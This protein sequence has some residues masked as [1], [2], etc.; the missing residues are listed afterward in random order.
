VK[1][2]C[3]AA[4]IAV[5]MPLT[6]QAQDT[7]A[8]GAFITD[9]AAKNNFNGSV[10]IERN[11]K[12]IYTKSFGQADFAFAIPNTPDT[13]Y[14]I[15]SITKLFTS[16]LI[17]QLVEQKRL[18]LDKTVRTYLP[19][20]TGPAADKV[21]LRQLLNHTAGITN[22]DTVKSAEDA[23]KNGLP[24]YQHPYTSRQ[25][26]DKFASGPLVS[27]PGKKWD[28]DNG[29]YVILGQ[30]IE[31]EYGQ[32]FEQ[33]LK[34]RILAPL[35]MT[36]SGIAHQADII[37]KLAPTYFYRD[38]LK[39]LANDFPV[40]PENWYAAGAMYSTLGDL[41]LFSDALFAG[42]LVSNA[43]LDEMFTPGLE[44]Y[45]Y[46]LWSY[47]T[48]INGA[49]YKVVKRPGRIMGAQ[50][51][52]YHFFDPDVT[53]ILLSNTGTTDLDEFVAQIGKQVVGGNAD[54]P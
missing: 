52:L 4:F 11:G 6:A 34:A 46:G 41:K 29:D 8:T 37:P 28:Y 54:K 35:G 47:D 49:E 9:Y 16:T 26:M 39:R 17:M 19:D 33:V 25:L 24:Q 22:F 10:L 12:T 36:Q 3:L 18:E 45:G 48:K 43:S 38:D 1:K 51:E 31:R 2:L 32:P 44:D 13:K 23:I 42:R 20:Y 50:T 53:I 40:Y 30:I 5:A 7:E 27:E 14:R 15:A 21:T